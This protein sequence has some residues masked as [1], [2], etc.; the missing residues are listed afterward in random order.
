VE[1]GGV[2]P[3]EGRTG[4][5][6]GPA[7]G[8]WEITQLDGRVRVHDGRGIYVFPPQRWRQSSPVGPWIKGDAHQ[9][10]VPG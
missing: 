7:L 5:A 3:D 1:T 10:T 8:P 6:F 2:V 9:Y 4:S